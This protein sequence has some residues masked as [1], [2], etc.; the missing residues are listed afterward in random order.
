[1]KVYITC[2]E[3]VEALNEIGWFLT[4][5]SP[6]PGGAACWFDWIGP[7]STN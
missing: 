6:A 1:M 3:E 7:F 5:L 2:M 4:V